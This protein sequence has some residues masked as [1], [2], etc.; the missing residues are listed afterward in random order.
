MGTDNYYFQAD[1]LPANDTENERE[2]VNIPILLV[3]D[4]VSSPTGLARITRE[5]ALRIHANLSDT[6]EVATCGPGGTWSKKFPFKQYPV[7]VQNW[8]IPELPGVWYDFAGDRKGIM[9]F[10]WNA[11]WLEWVSDPDILPD[12]DLKTFLKSDRI[13]KWIYAPIDGA[14]ADGKLVKSQAKMFNGFNRVLAYTKFGAN[15]IDRTC[16]WLEGTTPYLPHGT[17]ETVFFPRDRKEARA[18]FI[19]KVVQK[20]VGLIADDIL[21]CGCVATN[22]P[23]KDWG[24]AFETCGELLKRGVNVGLWAHT[25]RFQKAQVWDLLALADEFGMRL[26]TIFTNGNLDDDAM[27]WA[28]AACD[29]TL[30]IGSG[31]GWGLPNSEAL[32]CGVPCI[33][34]DYAGAAEFTPEA[35]K[36]K[37][38]AFRLDGYYCNK[39]PVFHAKDWAD[40]VIEVVE[41]MKGKPKI[42][43]LLQQYAWK[44]CWPAWEEWL[45]EGVHGKQESSK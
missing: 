40:K 43:L 6:F 44:N 8:T 29:V 35:F 22:T 41:W 10:V 15:V 17:D 16:G 14:G 33:T 24:L 30:G 5:L 32:A 25:D 1:P 4:S 28:Y 7:F 23:R 13:E 19:E 11:S 27:S 45:L 2:K 38:A 18:C 3:S 26:R 34:G 36:I 21:L 42:P 31:E 39:R 37:P 9:L 20:G 12:G